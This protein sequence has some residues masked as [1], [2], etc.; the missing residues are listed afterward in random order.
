[1]YGYSSCRLN[2]KSS[3]VRWGTARILSLWAIKL[4][5]RGPWGFAISCLLSHIDPRFSSG[6]RMRTEV[7]VIC[8]GFEVLRSAVGETGPSSTKLRPVWR[9]LERPRQFISR[10]DPAPIGEERVRPRAWV[11]RLSESGRVFGVRR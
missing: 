4:I 5:P 11:R 3:S 8:L 10:P 6:P 9:R 2:T 7:A 1:M